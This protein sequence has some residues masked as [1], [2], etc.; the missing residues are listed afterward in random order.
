[1]PSDTGISKSG[2]NSLGNITASYG[3][4]NSGFDSSKKLVVTATSTH[5]TTTGFYLASTTTGVTDTISYFVATSENDSAATTKFEFTADEINAKD[6]N[7]A[8]VGTSKPIGVS[9][10]DYSS[11][12]A[13]DYEDEITYEVSVESAGVSLNSGNNVTVAFSIGSS[14]YTVSG[15]FNGTT[16]TDVTSDT[17]LTMTWD[18]DNEMITVAS[19]SDSSDMYMV[20]LMN[21]LTYSY[22]KEGT[23]LS[24]I[25]IGGSDVTSSFSTKK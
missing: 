19:A 10:E 8:F 1:V 14:S 20:F 25:S 4:T 15:T 13:G 11:K 3:G 22:Y 17:G 12:S 9:V 5:T 18:A 6:T 21:G 24:S 23:T 7:D 16:F 2:W